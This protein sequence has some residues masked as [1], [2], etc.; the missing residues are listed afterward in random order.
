MSN[1]IKVLVVDDSALM[2]KLISDMLNHDPEI[3]VVGIAQNGRFALDK[4][5]LLR[6]DVVTLD[7]EMP[8]MDGIEALTR[9]MSEEPLPVVMISAHTQTGAEL[10]FKALELG[11]VD[12]IT[13]PDALFARPIIDLEHEICMKVK[14]ATRVRMRKLDRKVVEEKKYEARLTQLPKKQEHR[15]PV[16]RTIR[17]LVS[18]GISTGGPEALRKIL[19]TIPADFPAAMMI[20]QHMPP[21]F[22]RAFAERMDTLSRVEVCEAIDNEPI[23]HGRVYI[24]PGDFHMTITRGNGGHVA[25]I[26]KSEKVNLFRPSIDVL[27]KSTAEYFGPDNIGII[28]TGMAHDGVEGIRMTKEKGGRTIA[29]DEETSVVYGMNKLAVQSGFVDKILPLDEIFPTIL[30][31]LK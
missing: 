7:V 19:P 12:F 6:P 4:I 31:W 17:N 8:V 5:S 13:K 30:K 24:A 28:M 22:T 21:G 15:T 14:G 18:I 20:V 10:T 29:Q 16:E 27:M 2:R 11:A 26:E 3:E 23:V 25:R 1:K 9:I